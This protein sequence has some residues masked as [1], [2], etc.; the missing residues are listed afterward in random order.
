MVTASLLL[1]AS[2][3]DWVAVVNRTGADPW[4]I[5]GLATPLLAAAIVLGLV[6][7]ALTRHGRYRAVGVLSDDDR[8]AVRQAIADA[9]RRTVGEILPVV[10][11]RSDPHPA[12]EW[13]AALGFLL[14]GSA[15]LAP[16][17]PWEHP[18]L[19]L[20]CQLAMGAAGFAL[21]RT[22]PGFKRGFVF[23]HRATDVAM[24]QAFQEFWGNGLHRTE[25]A[26]GVL[27]FVSLFE[28]R[29]VVLAD[30]GI[31][32]KVDGAVWESTREAILR[33]IR[34][35]ALRDGLIDGIRAVS[36]VLA[37]HFPWKEGDRDEIPN[38]VIVRRE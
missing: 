37:I 26:T 25:A 23:E 20:L 8:A 12:A 35:G 11:E 19:V 22:L 9:E 36:D 31:H 34:R 10:V 21:A 15:L 17:L 7:H 6:L 38:R 18:A 27:L 29:V 4:R 32:A 13:L 1:L 30:E 33:G 24:E 2:G 5:V 14:V 28:R 16:R 3:K